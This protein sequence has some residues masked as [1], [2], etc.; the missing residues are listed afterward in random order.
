MWLH[1]AANRAAYTC[2]EAST[3]PPCLSLLWGHKVPNLKLLDATFLDVFDPRLGE[4]KLP[5]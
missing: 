5:N 1:R 3:L 2:L 4:P